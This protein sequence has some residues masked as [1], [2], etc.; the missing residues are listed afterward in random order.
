MPDKTDPK[1]AKHSYSHYEEREEIAIAQRLIARS[2]RA[3]PDLKSIDRIP[4]IDGYIT[5]NDSDGISICTFHT[6]VKKLENSS[7]LTYSFKNEKF[8]AYCRECSNPVLFIC[9]DIDTDMCYWLYCD[10]SYIES[11]GD[12]KTIKLLESQSFDK[13]SIDAGRLSFIDNWVTIANE[14]NRKVFNF[15]RLEK[16][17]RT[18][19]SRANSAVGEKKPDYH[20]IHKFLDVYN[21]LVENKFAVIKNRYFPG[22]WKIGIAYYEFSP[23]KLSYALYPISHEKN[24]VQIKK[25][26]NDLHKQLV[27]EGL[28]FAMHLS[29]NPILNDP[30]QF[31]FEITSSR[32]EEIIKYR[33]L[34]HSGIDFLALEFI[35]GFVDEFSQQMGLT[36]GNEYSF[37]EIENAYRVNLPLWTQETV[38]LINSKSKNGWSKP[39]DCLTKHSYDGIRPHFDPASLICFINEDEL[40]EISKTV[41]E[42]KSTGKFQINN[43]PVGNKDFAFGIFEDLLIQLKQKGIN[44]IYKP[45]NFSRIPNGGWRWAVFSVEDAKFNLRAFFEALPEVFE[46][47]VKNNFPDLEKELSLFRGVDKLLVVIHGLKEEYKT[48]QDSPSFE[49][50]YLKQKGGISAKQSIEVIFDEP[51]NPFP[52]IDLRQREISY[53]GIEYEIPYAGSSVKDF[54]FEDLPMMEF[55][56]DEIKARLSDYLKKQANINFFF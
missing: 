53:Q 17:F 45:K 14:H 25:V 41:Q 18:L 5:L 30:R 48:I 8:F 38:K 21:D 15:E 42:I 20:Q 33:L 31:A 36:P 4:N 56:Y 43:W 22:Q 24:D 50:L 40:K 39:E 52:E 46:Q 27:A 47:L 11:L 7:D 55:V 29:S 32:L 3:D 6:Q 51:S 9:V 13:A 19:S 35:F 1:P 16:A 26:D 49:Y 2:K 28:G 23:T 44:R 10:R 54:I 12:S 34:D 37:E